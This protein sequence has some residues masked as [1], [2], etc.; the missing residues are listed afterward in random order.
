MIKGWSTGLSTV[1]VDSRGA[2]C[3][4]SLP[5]AILMQVRH[6]QQ[7]AQGKQAKQA[8]AR[9]QMCNSV[10][11]DRS[12]LRGPS[13]RS[14]RIK[15]P[16]CKAFVVFRKR[17]TPEGGLSITGWVSPREGLG[18]EEGLLHWQVAV[19]R[20]TNWRQRSRP[21]LNETR[22]NTRPLREREWTDRQ[23]SKRRSSETAFRI[24]T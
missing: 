17:T 13:D 19:N 23:G 18:D 7:D 8:R 14:P 24:R 2:L 20:T 15:G 4:F 3:L 6:L 1:R 12:C 10:W 11:I 9:N 16:K 21:K 22:C 5:L